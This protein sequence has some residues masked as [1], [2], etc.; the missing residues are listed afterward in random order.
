MVTL[1]W[2]RGHPMRWTTFVA[3]RVAEIQR[4]LPD[5]RWR[6]VRT[7]HNPADCAS[8]GITPDEL[9]N[10][11]LWWEGPE[12]LRDGNRTYEDITEPDQDGN[13]PEQRRAV[14][15]ARVEGMTNEVLGRFSTLHRLLRVTAWI[16]RWR[17]GPEARKQGP[18]TADELNRARMR[19]ILLE[20]RSGYE[21][22]V[23]AL[24][25][26]RAISTSS[27]LRR[28]DPF[29]DATGALR[30]GGRLRHATMNADGRHPIILPTGSRLTQLIVTACHARTL[31]GGTQLTLAVVRQQYWIPR[32]RGLVRWLILR[33]MTCARWRAAVPQ[34]VMAD[35]PV[36][37]ITPARPFSRTGVDYEGPVFMRTTKGRGYKAVKAFI[38][39]FVCLSTRAV[40]LEAVSDYTAEVFLATFRRFVSRRGLCRELFSDCGT[41]FV[42]ADSQLRAL[43]KASGQ[44]ATQITGRLAEEG[45]RWRFNPPSAPHFGGL[46]EAAVKAVEHHLRRVIGETKLTFEE[47]ATFLAE[48]E[49]CLNSRPL[50][51]MSDDPEDLE[52]LTLGHFLIG[53]PLVSVP[54]PSLAEVSINRLT[55]WSML[56]QMRDHLWHRWSQEYVTSLLPRSK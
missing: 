24:A 19:W 48:V 9:L 36:A 26:N 55:R 4:T 28:L 42:G 29:V 56:Q 27:S 8:S 40:H 15:T 21:A 10:H 22:E 41:N 43:F 34:P 39:V 44:E 1:G 3:N 25:A 17:A 13:L 16:L 38:C 46:W 14:N 52:A 11:P 20:Q 54:E 30:A 47:L 32:G 7:D 12:W 49:A 18:L 31:H 51:A 2:I 50:Q 23:A 5:G 53:A 33:C 6:H 37:R 45:V 35:L